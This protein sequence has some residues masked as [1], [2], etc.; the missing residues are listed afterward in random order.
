MTHSDQLS[1]QQ[2][3]SKE[4]KERIFK[5]AKTILQ[6]GGYE[7]LSIKNICEQAGVSNGSFYHHF[8][9]KD[10]LL[11]YYIE[12]Q[13][14]INPDL[15]EIPK[16]KEEAIETIVKVYLNYVAYCRELGVEFMSGY[17]NPHNQ[18]LNPTI[19]TERSYPIVTVQKYLE[20]SSEAGAIKLTLDISAITT[21]IRMIV[22]G[23]VF[24][25]SM[26]G[27]EAPFEENMRRTLT[28]YLDSIFVS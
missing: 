8:K 18:A 2:L 9:T 16:G 5:A 28:H 19:R 3:K 1:K 4:T 15:L 11:S 13:P 22:I 21:D 12:K 14:S 25:W 7:N 23:N 26:R 10:D 6:K 24:E 20:K 27:G 17:Y